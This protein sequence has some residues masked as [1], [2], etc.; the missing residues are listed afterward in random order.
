MIAATISTGAP[1]KVEKMIPTIGIAISAPSSTSK[2]PPSW[3]R[4]FRSIVIVGPMLEGLKCRRSFLFTLRSMESSSSGVALTAGEMLA[5][6][7][8]E[9]TAV[10]ETEGEGAGVGDWPNA[11]KARA[12]ELRQVKIVVFIVSLV[13]R[14][15]ADR[16]WIQKRG[17]GE[18]CP[19]EK[20]ISG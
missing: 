12:I 9:A 8:A 18:V 11:V 3:C 19:V 16:V 1:N 4:W 14:C 10:A 5:P 17:A 2:S 6:A 15:S 13:V 20:S 7:L